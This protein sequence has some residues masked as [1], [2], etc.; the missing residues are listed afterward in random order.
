MKVT[1]LPAKIGGRDLIEMRIEPIVRSGLAF[2]G[3]DL[4]NT[5]FSNN[6]WVGYLFQKLSF[7]LTQL[8]YDNSEKEKSIF[9]GQREHSHQCLMIQALDPYNSRDHRMLAWMVADDQ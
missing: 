1:T 6:T 9:T 3:S 8:I 4:V 5:G 7:K 2:E